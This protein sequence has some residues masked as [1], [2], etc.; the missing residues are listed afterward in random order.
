MT[1]EQGSVCLTFIHVAI[2]N[3]HIYVFG[4]FFFLDLYT[5]E[6]ISGGS[7]FF[8]FVCVCVYAL[9]ET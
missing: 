6:A 5:W 2:C 1:I 7:Y 8:I 4:W 9:V 3:I